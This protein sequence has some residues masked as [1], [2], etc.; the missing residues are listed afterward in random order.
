MQSLPSVVLVDAALSRNYNRKLSADALAS[1]WSD[2]RG[3]CDAFRAIL[4]HVCVSCDI[5][6]LLSVCTWPVADSESG[7]CGSN[8]A[9]E[10]AWLPILLSFSSVP[11][12]LFPLEFT[13][14]N[15]F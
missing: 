14:G 4:V 1:L 12:F 10:D 3:I 5:S 11:Q 6:G 9:Y 13:S 15:F 8:T 2:Q 7:S